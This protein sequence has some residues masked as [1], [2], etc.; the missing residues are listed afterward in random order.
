MNKLGIKTAQFETTTD[1]DCIF[2][3]DDCEFENAK[4]AHDEEIELWESRGYAVKEDWPAAKKTLMVH[5]W[6]HVKTI[7]DGV[8][9][10]GNCLQ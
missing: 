6:G 7:I 5:P 4:S 10:V 8:A 3:I 1:T 9:K 2:E